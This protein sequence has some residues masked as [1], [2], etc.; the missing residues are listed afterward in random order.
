MSK[1]RQKVVKWVITLCLVA[2]AVWCAIWLWKT[3]MYS[4]WTR[5]ARVR[6]EVITL[7][8]DVSGWVSELNVADT[9]RVKQGDVILQIDQARYAAALAQAKASLASAK[10]TLRLKEHEAN[11]RSRLTNRAISEE[12]R[13]SARLEAEVARADVQQAEAALQSAQLDLDRT[14]LTAPADGSILNMHL[15]QGNYVTAGTSVMALIKDDSF[16]L[17]AYFQETKLQHVRKGDPVQITLMSG[18]KDFK[19]RVVGIGEG[20]ADDN[21]ATNAQQLPQVS[22]TFSWVRLA[23]RIPVRVEFDDIEAVRASGVNL[24]AG[25][26]ASVRLLSDITDAEDSGH[27]AP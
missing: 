27:G 16:Y 3:Y 11:R 12:E 18:N 9:T 20:I 13:D 4:P 15:T 5:D 22:A 25:M 10:A 19:G 26:T 24:A 1:S 8:P 23:Q 21:T 2:V 17:S 14:Q 6:A 7:S